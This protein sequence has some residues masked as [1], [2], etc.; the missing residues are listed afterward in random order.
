MINNLA[1]VTY[2]PELDTSVCL[3]ALAAA[4]P[5][6]CTPPAPTDGL[7]S[8]TASNLGAIVPPTGVT[9]VTVP[10]NGDF[11]LC[12]VDTATGSAPCLGG[13]FVAMQMQGYDVLFA[14][15][16]VLSKWVLLEL[17]G[18]RPVIVVATE[19]IDI[20]GAIDVGYLTDFLDT[21]PR[22]GAL[23]SGPGVG[24]QYYG[25]GAFC[26]TGGR[27]FQGASMGGASYGNASLTP[28]L[29]G[30][31]GYD[32]MNDSGSGGGALQLIAGHKIIVAGLLNAT[33]QKGFDA[34]G[35]S[36]GALLLEAPVI[37]GA[38]KLD[39][40]G[41]AGAPNINTNTGGGAAGAG[42]MPNGGDATVAYASGGGGAG[43]IRLNTRT[44]S[45]TG[46]M[47]PAESTGCATVGELQ[48][49]N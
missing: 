38:G 27:G 39:A 30:S 25:G 8:F 4:V 16:L 12:E 45:F 19:T 24:G 44:L 29:G 18:T 1:T 37:E 35:G 13:S 15:S 40:H 20:H 5:G 31:R 46:N 3:P 42:T 6:I 26:G 28:L 10:D 22:P 23:S 47:D 2:C 36:G 7:D 14:R 11:T 32:A 49:R 21:T 43:R 48:P 33:G 34:P 41:G 9:D 17:R